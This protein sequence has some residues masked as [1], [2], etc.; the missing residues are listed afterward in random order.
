M[1]ERSRG[2][3]GYNNISEQ[4]RINSYGSSYKYPGEKVIAKTHSK[5]TRMGEYDETYKIK[6]QCC[7][8]LIPNQFYYLNSGKFKMS[9]LYRYGIDL[10][11]FFIITRSYYFYIFSFYITYLL[12]SIFIIFFYGVPNEVFNIYY[13]ELYYQILIYGNK[14]GTSPDDTD[15]VRAKF[16]ID[17]GFNV[18]RLLLVI[19]IFSGISR[20]FKI[21]SKEYRRKLA[22]YYMDESLYTIIIKNLPKM[23]NKDDLKTHLTNEYNIE[24]RDI[25]LLKCSEQMG[26]IYEDYEKLII[27]KKKMEVTNI[28]KKYS[29]EE[30]NILHSDLE[31]KHEKLLKL[32][33]E[34]ENNSTAIVTLEKIEDKNIFFRDSYNLGIY[35]LFNKR[36][37][38]IYR[39]KKIYFEITP[40]INFIDWKYMGISIEKVVTDTYYNST[41]AIIV[42]LMFSALIFM[43]TYILASIPQIKFNL[44]FPVPLL[45]PNLMIFGNM[46]I[47]KFL[48]LVLS[49][50]KFSDKYFKEVSTRYLIMQKTFMN[51]I[52]LYFLTNQF[53]TYQDEDFNF[54]DFIFFVLLMALRAIVMT[55]F[56]EKYLLNRVHYV[57]SRIFCRKKFIQYELNEIWGDNEFNI[58]RVFEYY[59]V[60]VYT[61]LILMKLYPVST[62][63]LILLIFINY[64]VLRYSLY[65]SSLK[66][67]NHYGY[68]FQITLKY[69]IFSLFILIF[70]SNIFA[71]IIT[72]TLFYSIVYFFV[73]EIGNILLFQFNFKQKFTEKNY[74]EYYNNHEYRK[75]ANEK[76]V[77]L[78][79]LKTEIDTN[80]V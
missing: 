45:A 49:Q 48:E 16:F 79:L 2:S 19:Y 44:P 20:K 12:Q 75:F 36:K 55:R 65:H 51:T 70:I 63:V 50:L 30:F 33:D 8:R 4:F 1:R 23:V 34:S 57:L 24:V 29:D 32:I 60:S 46:L 69:E 40:S 11:N 14:N 61:C 31:K 62:L 53:K 47:E 41:V 39:G 28:D 77:N 15:V 3:S 68:Y 52:I 26:E 37:P 22:L 56:S 5:T 42:Y 66:D 13:L 80:Y 18:I 74:T 38:H 21:V 59:R 67:I 58:M 35:C 7:G 9:K 64:Y 27:K 6:C 78:Q 71:N 76:F 73:S 17:F 25:Q 54:Y 72:N 43:I 10:V